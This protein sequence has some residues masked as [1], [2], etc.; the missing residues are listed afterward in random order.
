MIVVKPGTIYILE[1]YSRDKDGQKISFTTKSDSGEY[2]DGITNEEVVSVLLDRFLY[3]NSKQPNT[4]NETLISLA[5]SMRRLLD[6][7]L[8]QKQLIH[9][10]KSKN[11][12][13]R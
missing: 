9:A 1:T 12:H 5:K 2:I 13:R 4:I 8:E 3:L 11:R 7:R 10:K 6:V